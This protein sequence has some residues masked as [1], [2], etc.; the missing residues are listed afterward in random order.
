V[1]APSIEEASVAE[2]MRVAIT[3]PDGDVAEE[4]LRLARQLGCEEVVLARPTR[5]PIVNGRWTYDDLMR[6]RGWVESFDLRLAAITNVQLEMWDKVRLGLPGREEQIEHYV[7]SV[8]NIGR[9]GIPILTHNFRPDPLY[10]T[11]HVAGRGGAE[12]TAFDRAKVDATRLSFGREFNAEHMWE[13]YSYFITRALR[14]LKEVGYTGFLIDDH[15]PGMV[16]DVEDWHHRGRIYQ[17]GYL[18]GLLRAIDDLT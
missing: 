17:T 15:P 6:L 11:H 13:A 4:Q 2:R 16:G 1:A 18:Q 8:R 10:R 5:L 7:A 9:A 12:V 14:T 3:M